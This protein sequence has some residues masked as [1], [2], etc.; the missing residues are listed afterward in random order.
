MTNGKLHITLPEPAPAQHELERVREIILGQRGEPERIVATEPRDAV[1]QIQRAE[2]DRL[3][4]L[5]MGPQMEDY[6]RRFSD[7]RREQ[8][9]VL[10]DLRRIQERTLEQ[11]RAVERRHAAL[12]GDIRR[13]IDEL[14]SEQERQRQRDTSV[15]QML[16]GQ[17]QVEQ[18][19]QT[20]AG[21]VEELR[22][23]LNRQ[24][25]EL[26]TLRA[27][28]LDRQE[29]HE[30]AVQVLWREVRA[31]HDDLRT[32]LHRIADRIDGQKVDRK[33]LAGM[34]IEVATRLETGRPVTS[35]LGELATGQE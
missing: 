18:V 4:D 15:R 17:T 32:D 29:T 35:L 14:R 12:D 19:T 5:L 13:A 24:G 1:P 22:T 30:R 34:L 7:S 8:E 28:L 10:G 3:R 20:L 33:A 16:A 6:D 2:V 26:R 27:S 21:Q 31:A 11:E 25:E 9:R 23:L